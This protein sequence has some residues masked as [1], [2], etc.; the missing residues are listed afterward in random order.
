MP[1]RAGCRGNE[2]A[3]GAVLPVG[4]NGAKLLRDWS[5]VIA[6]E[7]DIG[8]NVANPPICELVDGDVACGD[9][10]EKAGAGDVCRGCCGCIRDMD[11]CEVDEEAFAQGS[12]NASFEGVAVDLRPETRFSKSV[13]SPLAD[14]SMPLVVLFD[15][16]G[17][18][19]LIVELAGPVFAD[20]SWSFFVCSDSILVDIVL[21]NVIYAWNC[22]KFRSGPRANDQSIGK[23][24][25][26]R[27]SASTTFPME[28]KT[29]SADI[30][31]KVSATLGHSNRFTYHDCWFLGLDS[32]DEGNNF[33]LNSIFVK[34]HAAC[35]FLLFA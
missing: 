34:D 21:I 24:S 4:C 9:D 10:Q 27:K 18:S 12:S 22:C 35:W 15:P 5:G 13:S 31:F 8:C 3:E 17:R 6:L 11:S 7:A 26:A 2:K 29:A 16:N 25:S 20:R 23:I 28:S 32:F 19:P 1:G 33:L 14:I 30:Y